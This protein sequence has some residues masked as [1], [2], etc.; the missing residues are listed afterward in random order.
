MPD[1]STVHGIGGSRVSTWMW[2]LVPLV[3]LGAL[4]ALLLQVDPL[5]MAGAA[6]PPVE[7][8]TIQRIE[9]TEQGMSAHVVNGGPEPVTV[10]QVQV[11]GAY[12]AY[13]IEPDH[14]IP[15]LGE[16]TVSI[17]YPWVEGETH[18]V[19]LVTSTG[20]LFSKVIDVA[21]P[22]PQ[23][24][25]RLFGFFALLGVYVGVIPVA[26]GLLWFPAL[27]RA[28]QR[29]VDFFLFLTIGLLVF[30]GVDAVAEAIELTEQ[31]PAA[32]QGVGILAIGVVSAFTGL[33]AVQHWLA[34]SGD[35][36]RSAL[37]LAYMVALGIGLHN[38]GEGLAIGAAFA[39]G[40]LALGRM[41]VLGFTLHNT[42]EGLAIV[43][44][45][46]RSGAKW[47]HLVAM[48]AIAGVPTI[49][50]AWLG[51]FTY[52]PS[53]ALLFLAVGAGAIFQVVWQI[54]GQVARRTGDSARAGLLTPM[55]VS[56]LVLGLGLMYVTGLFVAA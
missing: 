11:D 56:G 9:L 7:E 30:L 38:L 12:W 49:L 43:A 31:V 19:T 34:P 1:S 18:V 15:R 48:G 53:W 2:A 47:P 52:A 55:N 39:L 5:R 17:P 50:G 25:W 40:S 16:A 21:V 28:S 44:P 41:L 20:L 42:T 51:G 24:S 4:V 33:C 13:R 23:P 22:T 32:Y 8:L 6:F 36:D 27:R 45:L 26:V 10:A 29:W 37:T 14:T 35:E 54:G 46:A 3:L